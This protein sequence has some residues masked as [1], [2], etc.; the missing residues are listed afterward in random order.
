MQ[1][2]EPAIVVEG[3]DA[4]GSAVEELGKGVLEQR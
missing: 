1:P 2:P 4:V 3:Q